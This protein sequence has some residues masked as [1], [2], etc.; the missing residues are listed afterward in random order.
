MVFL[1]RD[2]MAGQA[3]NANQAEKSLTTHGIFGYARPL[4][5]ELETANLVLRWQGG[6]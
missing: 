1:S 6:S 3:G 2:G 5:G 4:Q